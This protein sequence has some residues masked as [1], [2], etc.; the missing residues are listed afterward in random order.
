MPFASQVD[1]LLS[2]LRSFSVHSGGQ[3][4]MW[5]I[6]I[7]LFGYT[8]RLLFFGKYGKNLA[9]KAQRRFYDD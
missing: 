6:T 7:C 8:T 3:G 4:N 1:H 9:R 5:G 2:Y